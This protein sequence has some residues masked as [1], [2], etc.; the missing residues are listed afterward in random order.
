MV[1]LHIATIVDNPANGVC[2]VVPEHIKA[3]RNL[4]T[5]GLLNVFDYKPE[6]IDNCFCYKDIPTF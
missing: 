3:Q 2:V 5:V 4:A 6:G 1:I